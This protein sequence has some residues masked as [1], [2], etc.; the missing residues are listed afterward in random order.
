M[1]VSVWRGM[2]ML[3]TVVSVC[4]CV[5][6]YAVCASVKRGDGGLIVCRTCLTGCLQGGAAIQPLHLP[7]LFFLLN[8][9]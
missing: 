2:L 3:L 1:G 8:Y 4:V 5:L 9:P 6:V 7:L